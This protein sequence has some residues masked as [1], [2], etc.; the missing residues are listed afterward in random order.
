M[1]QKFNQFAHGKLVDIVALQIYIEKQKNQ[2]RNIV[3]KKM[4]KIEVSYSLL[5]RLTMDTWKISP[6]I[7]G[8]QDSINRPTQ[9]LLMDYKERWKGNFREK[10]ILTNY[11]VSVGD[12][13]L[14]FH[15][16]FTPRNRST[17][18]ASEWLSQ[19]SVCILLRSR[20][21]GLGIE[22]HVQLPAQ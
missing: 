11:D 16:Y 6:Q 9:M 10:A 15:L 4:N 8:N 3:L 2:N 18:G 22:L 19:L 14:N 5:W 20:S 21:Q 12:P 17:W 13:K 7:N 1:K